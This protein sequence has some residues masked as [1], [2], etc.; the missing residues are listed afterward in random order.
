VPRVSTLRKSAKDGAPD[1][2]WQGM[3][4]VQVLLNFKSGVRA[5]VAAFQHLFA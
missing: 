5:S 3:E 1:H 4:K 2:L